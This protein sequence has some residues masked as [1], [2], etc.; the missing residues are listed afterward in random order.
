[1]VSIVK[2]GSEPGVKHYVCDKK[3]E[4]SSID[5]R[6]TKMGSTCFV[7]E[8]SKTYMLNGDFSWTAINATSGSTGGSSSTP[9]EDDDNTYIADGGEII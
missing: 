9:V 5:L 8:Q 6:T 1:M 3:D 2:N 7:I 4:L